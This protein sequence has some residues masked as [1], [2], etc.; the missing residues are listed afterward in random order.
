MKR[1]VSILAISACCCA[2]GGAAVSA[3]NTAHQALTTQRVAAEQWVGHVNGREQRASCELQTQK[4]ALGQPCGKLPT[5]LTQKCPKAVTG[6]KRP[7]RKSEIRTIEEQVG[8]YT[9]ES[10]TRGFVTIAAQLK[11]SK[12]KGVLGLEQ[13]GSAWLVTYLRYGS[14]TVVPA[15]NVFQS[16]A[17]QKLWITNMCPVAHPQWEKG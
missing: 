3:A 7:Y 13:V 10:P 9:S 4:E 8:E 6:A 2:L 11:A 5:V 17:W 12:Q 14:E 15:G 16:Q 1:Y